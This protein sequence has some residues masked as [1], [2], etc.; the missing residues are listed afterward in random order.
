MAN[1]TSNKTMKRP[2]I[3]SNFR[4]FTLEMLPVIL[5][6]LIA[7]MINN[8]NENYKSKNKFN[9]AKAHIIQEIKSNK[10]ECEK[11]LRVQEN[12]NQFFKTYR[13]SLIKFQSK[14][15]SLA[16]LPFE[17]INVPSISRT[18]W[19][20]ANTSGITSNFSF[21]ELQILTAIYEMQEILDD[22]QKQIINNVYSNNMYS[23]ETL[24]ATFHSLNRLNSDYVDFIKS[25]S[26][27][28]DTYLKK[29][30]KQE[31]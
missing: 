20:A 15:L 26:I 9:L 21:E 22:V 19:D 5:G 27:A 28:Y 12:R 17:G 2:N 24:L 6:V 23:S 14:K 25:T 29:F 8:W 7:F 31:N 18:A 16:Q 1:L 30:S 10:D 4:K 11:I 13:D 3:A